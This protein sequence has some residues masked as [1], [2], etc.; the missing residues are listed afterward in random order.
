VKRLT[1]ILMFAMALVFVAAACGSSDDGANSVSAPIPTTAPVPTAAPAAS[2]SA[3]TVN[4][5][6]SEFS[7]S[8]DATVGGAGD[9][10][11]VTT[12]TG[13]LPHEFVILQSDVASDA[14]TVDTATAKADETA[15]GGA[16]GRIP[17]ADLGAGAS[18]SVSFNL[19]PGN[20]VLIC[21][22]AGHYQSGMTTAFTVQ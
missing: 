4:V 7:I 5:E 19:T 17:Q 2:A 16:I 6:L 13:A 20:Y 15:A 9:I 18:T 10:T 12:N 21:N 3:S 14:L 8:L 11:F 22:V 1:A